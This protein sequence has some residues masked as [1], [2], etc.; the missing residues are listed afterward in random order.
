MAGLNFSSATATHPGRDLRVGLG[1]PTRSPNRRDSNEELAVPPVPVVTV[2]TGKSPEVPPVTLA[3]TK[4]ALG[5][6]PEHSD[7]ESA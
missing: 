4:M 2:T 3:V 6:Q 7:S 1:P 5:W